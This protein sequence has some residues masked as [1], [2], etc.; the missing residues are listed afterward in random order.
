MTRSRLVRW[1]P[2]LA[3]MALLFTANTTLAQENDQSTHK[4]PLHEITPDF[5]LK[6]L[7]GKNLKLSEQRGDVVI[8]TFW[9]TWCNTCRQVLPLFNTLYKNYKKTGLVVFGITVD[10][11]PVQARRTAEQLGLTFPILHDQKRNVSEAYKLENT[12][13]TY[14]IARDGTLRSVREGFQPGI[15]AQLEQEIR[16]MLGE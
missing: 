12:P 10:D 13:T 15:E 4:L 8:L 11:D 7:H 14:L 9:A 6:A 16:Q 5:T 2:L 3:Y 1:V